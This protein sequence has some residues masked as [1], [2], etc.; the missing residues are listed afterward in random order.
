MWFK[1]INNKIVDYEK[2]MFIILWDFAVFQW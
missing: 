1:N 2:D